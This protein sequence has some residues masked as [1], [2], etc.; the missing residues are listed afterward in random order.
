[1]KNIQI[2]KPA[3]EPGKLKQMLLITGD[4]SKI[5][6]KMA[7]TPKQE[8]EFICSGNRDYHKTT[9]AIFGFRYA[10]IEIEVPF[11]ASAFHSIAV[12]SDMEETGSFHIRIKKSIS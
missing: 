4:E 10:E 9:F 12:Y 11:D 6:G 3:K 7:P 1:M 5:W 8:I 2:N